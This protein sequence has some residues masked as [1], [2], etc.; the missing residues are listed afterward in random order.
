MVSKFELIGPM[1]VP[2]ASTSLPTAALDGSRR[3]FE[4]LMGLIAM[5]VLMIPVLYYPGL[6]IIV[7][8]A[9]IYLIDAIYARI[10]GAR[11]KMPLPLDRR[12]S[13][14]KRTARDFRENTAIWSSGFGF[15][16]VNR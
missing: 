6:M 5:A 12:A 4:A 1:R 2:P 16:L 3:H 9:E 11:V 14:Q 15:G 8:F 7:V 13:S 10:Y